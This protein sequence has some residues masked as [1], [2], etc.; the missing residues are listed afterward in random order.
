M[1][2]LGRH[3]SFHHRPHGRRIR[4]YSI[5]INVTMH[6]DV[7]L[8]TLNGKHCTANVCYNPTLLLLWT[9][10]DVSFTRVIPYGK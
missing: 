10:V 7:Q 8:L 9:I 4:S 2:R 1:S 3:L 5:N 6:A